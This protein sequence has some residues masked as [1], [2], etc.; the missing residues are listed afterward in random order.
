MNKWDK[1][2]KDQQTIEEYVASVRRRMKY[3]NYAPILTISALSGQRVSKLFEMIRLAYDARH[4][5]ISTG[6]LNNIFVPDL[7]EQFAARDSFQKLKIRYITQAGSEPPTFVV[8]TS[9]R[10]RHSSWSPG[11]SQTL[12]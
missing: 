9:S 8:F 11:I 2:K 12:S 6:T 10:E 3:L 4:L 7:A 5:R 1:V